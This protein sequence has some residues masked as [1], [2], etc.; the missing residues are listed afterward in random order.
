MIILP[1]DLDDPRVGAMLAHHL[2]SARAATAPGS[3]HALD[4]EA[5]RAREVTVWAAWE[6]EALVGV[7]ALKRLS[8]EHGEIK[9]MHTVEAG[10]RRGIGRAMLLHIIEAARGMGMTRLS[11]ET[12]SWDYFR[13]ARRLYR[14][15]GFTDCPPFGDYGPDPNSVFLSLDLR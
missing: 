6:G 2:A 9:S 14:G 5:L 4:L 8:P 15:H 7:G 11:L 10:R 12:G 3:A 13:P 1:A